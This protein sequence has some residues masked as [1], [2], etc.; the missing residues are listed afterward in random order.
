MKQINI[1]IQI[2]NITASDLADIEAL[3][4]AS[5]KKYKRKRIQYQL[6]DTFGLPIPEQAE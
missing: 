3:V 6:G 5:L 2:D 1:N 4:E